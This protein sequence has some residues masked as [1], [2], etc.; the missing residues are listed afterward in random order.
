MPEIAEQRGVQFIFVDVSMCVYVY[1]YLP[2]SRYLEIICKSKQGGG[3]VK[4]IEQEPQSHFQLKEIKARKSR[5]SSR[6]KW[7]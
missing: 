2:F 6:D 5:F 7:K 1:K 4:E 3:K